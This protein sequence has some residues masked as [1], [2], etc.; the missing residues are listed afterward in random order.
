[1]SVWL[2]EVEGRANENLQLLDWEDSA[3]ETTLELE[4][5]LQLWRGRS[6]REQC[7]PRDTGRL[8]AITASVLDP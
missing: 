6:K 1:M 7:E 4:L 3:I 5:E 2:A 8:I